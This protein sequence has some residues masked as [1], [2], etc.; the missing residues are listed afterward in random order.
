M[1]T[2]ASGKRR[3]R[4]AGRRHRALDRQGHARWRHPAVPLGKVRRLPRRQA[5]GAVRPR[6]VDGLAADVRPD[7]SRTCGFLGHGLVRAARVRLL[8]RRPGGLRAFGQVARHLLRHRQR[9]R[10]SGGGDRL[11]R[12]RARRPHVHGLRDLVGRAAG[13]A[14]RAAPSRPHLAARARR[15]RLDR[16]WGADARAAPQE[17]ARVPRQQAA[18]DRPRVRLFDLRARSSGLRREARRRRVRGRDPG[19]RR[20]DAERH[21]HRHVLEAARRRPRPDH[22]ADARAARSVR[23]H[24]RLRRPD[25]ILQAAAQ[26]RQAV[27]RAGRHF[28][29]E[30]PAEELPARLPHPARVLHAAGSGVRRAGP[31][32]ARRAAPAAAPDLRSRRRC[33]C[34]G[35]FPRSKRCGAPPRWPW[36][37]PCAG[38]PDSARASSPRRSSRSCCP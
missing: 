21:L 6:L 7:G 8:V 34:P 33:R 4:R 17:A 2:Q 26:S 9:R 30:L 12:Q 5:G 16:R 13:R 31:R 29:C 35:R 11:H 20:L 23:R 19:A 10:R 3:R 32:R 36:G 24:R 18:A 1:T 15:V 25:R 38:S 14:V 22:G 28:A 37:T 27:L